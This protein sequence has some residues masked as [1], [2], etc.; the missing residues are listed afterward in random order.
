MPPAFRSPAKQLEDDVDAGLV[1]VNLELDAATLGRSGPS[2]PTTSDAV[3][4]VVDTP[5]TGNDDHDRACQLT[6]DVL[7]R[8]SH[9]AADLD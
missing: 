8:I 3:Q 5:T 4:N 1:K 6:S 7:A 9:P 2:R